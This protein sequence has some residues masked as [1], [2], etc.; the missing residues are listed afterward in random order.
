MYEVPTVVPE[1]ETRHTLDGL[2]VTRTVTG[3]V[4]VPSRAMRMAGGA[5][6]VGGTR[7][8]LADE[9]P[10]VARAR[11]VAKNNCI[12]ATILYPVYSGNTGPADLPTQIDRLA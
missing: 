9:N 4:V 5:E 10:V 8:L 1:S 7:R 2:A 3:L 12:V 11:R 6:P